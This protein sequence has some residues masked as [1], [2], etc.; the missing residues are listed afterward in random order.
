M[1]P[2]PHFHLRMLVASASSSP[3]SVRELWHASMQRHSHILKTRQSLKRTPVL[4][5]VKPNAT[6][7]LSTLSATAPW[8]YRSMARSNIGKGHFSFRR[9]LKVTTSNHLRQS[10]QRKKALP[11]PRRIPTFHGARTNVPPQPQ[12]RGLRNH[13]A[14]VSVCQAFLTSLASTGAALLF[15]ALGFLRLSFFLSPI[16]SV[17][18]NAK[19]ALWRRFAKRLCISLLSS[20]ASCSQ[21]TLYIQVSED[22]LAKLA[23]KALNSCCTSR[24]NLRKSLV[25]YG[26]LHRHFLNPEGVFSFTAVQKSLTVPFHYRESFTTSGVKERFRCSGH[27]PNLNARCPG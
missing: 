25:L 18:F 19:L 2:S 20:H 5:P 12:F 17:F 7:Q 11:R 16:K 10:V 26:K 9:T 1:R 23:G 13:W 27:P 21:M 14:R 3:A 6:A 4:E 24:G 15:L 22:P 8:K